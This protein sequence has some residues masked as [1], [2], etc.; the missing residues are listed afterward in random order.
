MPVLAS[1]VNAGLYEITPAP[2]TLH[3]MHSTTMAPMAGS[4]Q[5]FSCM[6]SPPLTNG[7]STENSGNV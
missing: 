2:T 1:S 4:L 3:S 6:D 5:N 7:L